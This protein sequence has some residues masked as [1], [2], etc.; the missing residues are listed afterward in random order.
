MDVVDLAVPARQIAV[1]RTHSCA[2]LRDGTVHCWGANEHAQLADGTTSHRAHPALVNGVFEV[3][4]V[5]AGGD[6]TC[7]RLSD[8][9]ERC[10]GGIALPKTEGAVLPVPAEVRW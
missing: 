6:A 3:E 4:E 2:L 8:G 9:S 1:G 5:A 7:V 10:W